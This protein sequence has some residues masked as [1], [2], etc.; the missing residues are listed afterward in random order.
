MNISHMVLVTHKITY[1]V[2][3]D[4]DESVEK[5][6]IKLKALQQIMDKEQDS[7]SCIVSDTFELLRLL[8]LIRVYH[9]NFKPLKEGA[10]VK[11]VMGIEALQLCQ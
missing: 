10:K 4:A 3:V 2:Q 11:L 5:S 8:F 7:A 1:M 9:K 6:E